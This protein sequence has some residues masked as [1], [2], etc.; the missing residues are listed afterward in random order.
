MH[1]K[2]AIRNAIVR[3]TDMDA[4]EAATHVGRVQVPSCSQERK[5]AI[6]STISI[7]DRFPAS[8]SGSTVVSTNRSNDP[9]MNTI[10]DGLGLSHPAP[11]SLCGH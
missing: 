3:S 2:E 11:H 6:K 1:V 4:R 9:Y 8:I 10:G 5:K 7:C